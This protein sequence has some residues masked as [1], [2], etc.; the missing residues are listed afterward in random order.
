MP[1][2]I[3]FFNMIAGLTI[4]IIVGFC[5]F[6]MKNTI[7]HAPN[8]NDIKTKIIKEKDGKYYRLVPQAVVCPPSLNKNIIINK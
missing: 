4:G 1:L 3:T 5:Y 8:S 2:L 6:N 7:Y